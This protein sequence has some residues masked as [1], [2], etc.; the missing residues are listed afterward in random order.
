MDALLSFNRKAEDDY[1]SVLGCDELST[2]SIIS[3]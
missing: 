1:Y 3:T 2:V